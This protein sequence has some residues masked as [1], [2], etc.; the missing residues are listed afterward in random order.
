M[1]IENENSMDDF[2]SGLNRAEVNCTQNLRKSPRM[3]Q[4]EKKKWK[5]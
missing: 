3:H 5:I 4:R 2:K 1:V